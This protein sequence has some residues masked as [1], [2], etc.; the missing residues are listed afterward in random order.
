VKVLA[1]IPLIPKPDDDPLKVRIFGR[2]L[3]GV[4]RQEWDHEI[5][6]LFDR[7]DFPVIDNHYAHL[8]W[9]YNK[10]RR[11]ALDGG[12][13]ALWTVE[14]DVIVP[15]DALVKLAALEADVAYGLYMNRHS[16]KVWL[17]AT[18]LTYERGRFLSADP[19]QA[20]AAWGSAVESRGVGM[21]CTLISRHVLEAIE[22]RHMPGPGHGHGNANDWYFAIDCQDQAFHQMHH[23]GVVC[24]HI[25][26]KP[27]PMIL[28]PDPDAELLYSFEPLPGVVI[29]PLEDGEIVELGLG[30]NLFSLEEAR[31]KGFTDG[32]D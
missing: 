10:A 1:Y 13:D 26:M 7:E 21:G 4:F 14:A 2:A 29:E 20:R 24:G 12:Y 3:M 11:M 28:W 5:H 30:D 15:Q 31:E 25:T 9:R 18:E 17:C 8:V 19:E 16:R 6:Y 32:K 22:F 23:L 27:A